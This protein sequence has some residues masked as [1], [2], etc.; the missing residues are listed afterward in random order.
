MRAYKDVVIKGISARNFHFSMK[1]A[2][3]VVCLIN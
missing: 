3:A 2:G 1:T